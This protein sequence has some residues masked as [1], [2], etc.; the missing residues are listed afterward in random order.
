MPRQATLPAWLSVHI[1]RH[2]GK[3]ACRAPPGY[4]YVR[5]LMKCWIAGI[6][7]IALSGCIGVSKTRYSESEVE[8]TT[9]RFEKYVGDMHVLPS[10]DLRI[11]PLNGKST[12]MMV[13]PIPTYESERELPS[14]RFSAFVSVV[15][16]R[17][18]LTIAPQSF[19]YLSPS[20]AQFEPASMVGPYECRSAQP[21]PAPNPSPLPTVVLVQGQCQTMLVTYETHAP[22]PAQRFRFILG[23][24]QSGKEAIGLPI[25]QFAESTR[26]ESVAIP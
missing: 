17:A 6:I 21:R 2:A 24:F 12:A 5:P 22:D 4:L 20:G 7:A 18:E 14:S 8:G 10:V 3:V 1:L 9:K 25:F 19:V 26:R 11:E 15:S 16:K 13:F 23:A